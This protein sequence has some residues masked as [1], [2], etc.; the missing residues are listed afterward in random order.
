[1]NCYKDTQLYQNFG[2]TECILITFPEDLIPLMMH[3]NT[4]TQANNKHRQRCHLTDPKLDIDVSRV[5]PWT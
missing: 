4:M 3:R 5:R 1:M 2:L